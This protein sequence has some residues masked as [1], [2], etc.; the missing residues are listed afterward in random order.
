VDLPTYTNIWRI[1]KRLYKLYDFRL[2]APLPINWIAVFTG[3]TVPYIL[4]LVAIGLPFNHTLVWLYVLPP[5]L[6]TWLTTRPVIESKRLPELLESQ[7]RYLTEPRSWCRMAPATEKDQIVLTAR[8]WHSHRL[9][10]QRAASLVTVLERGSLAKRKPAVPVRP[11]RV[12]VAAAQ[13]AGAPEA[14]PQ[15]T[16]FQG[17]GFQGTA[18]QGAAFQRGVARGVA[19]GVAGASAATGLAA[20]GANSD[21]ATN[22]TAKRVRLRGRASEGAPQAPAEGAAQAPAEGSA[23]RGSASRAIE[24]KGSALKGSALKGS[25]SRG[26]AWKGGVGK[27]LASPVVPAPPLPASEALHPKR[28]QAGQDTPAPAGALPLGSVAAPVLATQPEH[29]TPAVVPVLTGGTGNPVAG[30]SPSAGSTL[31]GSAAASAVRAMPT[32]PDEQVRARGVAAAGPSASS[33]KN[34]GPRIEVAHN[35]PAHRAVPSRQPADPGRL[36]GSHLHSDAIDGPRAPA[37]GSAGGTGGPP[38]NGDTRAGGSGPGP[39]HSPAGGRARSVARVPAAAG[40]RAACRDPASRPKRRPPGAFQPA[41]EQCRGERSRR[42]RSCRQC[43][44]SRGR[45]RDRRASLAFRTA[46][47]YRRHSCS[48]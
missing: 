40:H 47:V 6:L 11:A 15:G 44:R 13:R 14:V 8:V 2:P 31:A 3:I 12:L 43:P 1:E 7:I 32:G 41:G 16:G 38:A 23:S 28:Q 27:R 36:F 21:A 34:A 19:A 22:G 4:L 29:A 9:P 10:R 26:S 18:H 42:Q 24:P 30:V 5:G 25:A 20:G 33:G 45:S 35:G 37:I 17:T 39:G 48:G 46:R